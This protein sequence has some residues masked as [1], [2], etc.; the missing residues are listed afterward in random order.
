MGMM[1]SNV[2]AL[3]DLKLEKHKNLW[4]ES[5]FYWREITDGTLKFDRKEC[6]V[7]ALRQLTQKDLINFFDQYIKVGAPKKRSL[8][9]RVYG[10]SH[11]SESSSDKNE[12]VP[13]NSVQIGDIFCFRRSQPLYGSFKGG[14]GHMKL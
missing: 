2:N 6:E 1:Q 10:S 11:S 3:I 12:P 8:S 9:V 7:A 5:G 13:A 14:F 4:E